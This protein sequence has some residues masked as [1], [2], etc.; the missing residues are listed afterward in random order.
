[1]RIAF[2]N[3]K[4]RVVEA[5]SEEEQWLDAAL[6]WPDPRA[7]RPGYRGDGLTHAFHELTGTFPAGFLRVAVDAARQGEAGAGPAPAR[8]GARGAVPHD[9]RLPGR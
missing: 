9:R 2:D 6:S 5:T 8:P 1:M 3:V 7:K 4:A